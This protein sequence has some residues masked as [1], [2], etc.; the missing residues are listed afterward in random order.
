MENNFRDSLKVENLKPLYEQ[1][2]ME[3]E[4]LIRHFISSQKKQFD[5]FRDLLNSEL[6]VLKQY[7]IV[8]DFTRFLA[9]IKSIESSIK[10]DGVKALND[11]F[12]V[13]IDSPTPGETAFL[14][15]LFSDTMKK[16]KEAVHNKEN[17]YVAYH[18]SG[19]PVQ[20]N[21]YEKIIKILD[22]KF[23][24]NLMFESYK[25]NAK[26][27]AKEILETESEKNIREYFKKY[28]NE[29]NEYIEYLNSSLDTSDLKLLKKQ[30]NMYEKKYVKEIKTIN[31]DKDYQPVVEAQFK[32]IQTAIEANIGKASH[33]VYKGEDTKKIQKEFDKNGGLPL[34][35][36]PTM[37]RSNLEWDADFNPIPMK[38]LSSIEVAKATYPGLKLRRK[39]VKER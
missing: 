16:T 5:A 7:A 10:N 25:K 20:S 4:E 6:I 18:A 12:G 34:S 38:T 30:L 15:V 32:T 36:L 1:N 23:D 2:D 24:E 14:S 17:G 27:K 8:S 28:C 11:V 3:K 13:E 35:K 9:R 37:Y 31:K 19:F 21:L 22:T 39:N 33:E 26:N 29:L